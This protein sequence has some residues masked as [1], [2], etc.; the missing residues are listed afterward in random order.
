MEI[1]GSYN[2]NTGFIDFEKAYDITN[3]YNDIFIDIVCET[4][5]EGNT[6][7]PT[8][9][10]GRC[11][12]SKTPFIVYGGKN[13]LFNLK[14]L[15]FLTFGNIFDESYD[16]HEGIERIFKIKKIID[17]LGEKNYEELISINQKIDDILEHNLQVYLGLTQEKIK[18]VFQ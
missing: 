4:W 11:L 15:G 9:K 10:I 18:K 3:F 17:F 1:E 14:K 2:D 16:N 12:I 7:M 13:Y 6:F 8:E 5:H